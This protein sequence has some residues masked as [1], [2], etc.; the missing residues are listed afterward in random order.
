M[1]RKNSF[2]LILSAYFFLISCGFSP[3]YKISDDNLNI[4]NYSLKLVN[5]V[6][7]EIEDEVKNALYSKDNFVYEVLLKIQEEQTP[8]II[9]TNGTVSKYRIE[10]SI[11]FEIIEIVSNNTLSTGI[12]R[13]FAQYDVGESEFNNEDMKKSMTRN[14]VKNALQIMVSKVESSIARSNDN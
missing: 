13:G 8:L 3:I 12:A 11:N 10:V 14:A 5:N 9:N 7:R 2:I 6:S 1:T 4:R